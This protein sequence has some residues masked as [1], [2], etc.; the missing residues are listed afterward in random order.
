MKVYKKYLKENNY[1]TVKMELE[2]HPL[3]HSNRTPS[4]KTVTKTVNVD[5]KKGVAIIGK[6]KNQKVFS[7]NGK[8][9]TNNKTKYVIL[10]EF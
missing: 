2:R 5:D 6:G 7:Y 1:R 8:E 3:Y 10:K 9:L 4:Y